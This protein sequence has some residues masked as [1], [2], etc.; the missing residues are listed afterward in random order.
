MGT[1]STYMC[2]EHFPSDSF[3][4]TLTRIRKLKEGTIPTVFKWS[5]A[6]AERPPPKSRPFVLDQENH[7][8][9][10]EDIAAPCGKADFQPVPSQDHDYVT[11]PVPVT[12]AE[13]LQLAEEY[14][15]VLEAKL[16]EQI[17]T[18]FCIE[19]FITDECTLNMYT[20]F[21]SYACL[22]AVFESL[23]PTATI[24]TRWSQVQ[25]MRGGV[26]SRDEPFRCET[27]PLIDQFFLFLCRIQKGFNGHDLAICFG[28]STSTV[29]RLLI[30]LVNYL[31]FMLGSLP[32]WHPEAG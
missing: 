18:R 5:K 19:R 2:S 8:T 23:K 4:R 11:D 16:H 9:E 14:I 21:K 20:G 26:D 10:R 32:I 12:D 24:M 22:K 29:S 13:K 1:N 7:V 3:K 15:A 17:N 27:L 30:T 6:K 28:V 31:Y 25:R